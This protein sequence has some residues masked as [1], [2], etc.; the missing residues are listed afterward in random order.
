MTASWIR[1]AF[2]SPGL[3]QHPVGAHLDALQGQL[4]GSV[5][6]CIDV[7]GSMHGSSLAQAVEG[8]RRFVDEA[9]EAN[10]QVGIVLW[11]T[12]VKQSVKLG[13]SA[14]D[15]DKILS[16]ASAG[17]GT[18]LLPALRAADKQLDDRSGDRVVAIFG[19]GDMGDRE[20]SM[21][22]AESMKRR[23]IRIITCGLG[24]SSAQALD[25]IS[26]EG[27]DEPRTAGSQDVAEAIAG[28][29]SGL[30]R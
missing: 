4:S 21:R 1:K 12:S 30:R 26:S 11:D 10:Y 8:A 17:G 13:S 25:V 6:L 29:A 15:I 7:S 9:L 22:Q 16:M 18:N 27:R 23:D 5:V 28:M 20:G 2:A 14:R 24:G 3:T 19:D